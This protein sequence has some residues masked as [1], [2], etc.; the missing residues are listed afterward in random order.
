MK[1]SMT[2]LLRKSPSIGAA[3][4]FASCALTSAGEKIADA[5]STVPPTPV[6]DPWKFNLA[7]PGWLANTSG[8]IGLDGINSH[9]YLSAET[10]LKHIDMI[11]FLSAEARKGRFGMY[12]DFLYVSASDG[13]GNDGL[14]GKLDVR[15]DEYLV[16]LELNYR[17]FEGPRG[18]LDVRAGCRYTNIYNK[19]TIS[20]NDAEIDR[21]STELVDD[22]SQRI[23]NRVEKALSELDLKGRL[24]GI[25]ADRVRQGI[26]E[27]ITGVGGERPA[28]PIAPVGGHEP[29]RVEEII[30][31]I[32]QNR[33]SELGAA[34]RA[35]VEAKSDALRERARKRVTAF[36]QKLAND[37]A[38][39][40]RSELDTSF[41]LEEYWFDPYVGLG[42]RYNFNKAWY[43]TAKG[44]IGGFGV[45]S[46][47]TWQAYGALGCQVTRS[48]FVEAGYRYLYTD[49][50]HDGFLYKVTQSG[51]Q[52]T[53]GITF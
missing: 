26:T 16:D 44:D 28:L 15:L 2:T 48:I 49:Y 23:R 33:A 21:A 24:R 6:E 9:V 1:A 25:I 29:G 52:I 38:R 17:L 41:S 39:K 51:V 37:I 18:F 12:G 53:A 3:L 5:K 34:L 20:P 10:L 47:L 45:G 36:K 22:V 7:L 14:I 35:E 4:L 30:R 42:G 27:R 11:G 40:L 32:I 46:D 8:T 19:M 13:I 50:D 43:L 31:E